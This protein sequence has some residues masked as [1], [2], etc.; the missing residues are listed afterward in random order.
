MKQLKVFLLFTFVCLFIG[1]SDGQEKPFYLSFQVHQDSLLVFVENPFVCPAFIQY[2]DLETQKN[3]VVRLNA[4]EQRKIFS[5]ASSEMDSLSIYNAYKFIGMSY[6]D[7]YLTSY[8][9]LY[10]YGLP[11]LKGK[12]YKVMQGQNT[13]FTHKGA[14]SKYA[15]DF[16]MAVGQT[17]CAM[18]DGVVVRTVSEHDKTG[19]SKKYKDFANYI[20]LYHKDGLFTQYVHLKK[21]GVLVKVGDSVKKGQ[22]IGYSGNTGMST[23]PHLHFAVFKPT[24]TGLVSIPYILD[25]I[26]TH[27]YKKGKYAVNN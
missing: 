7:P 26:T 14:F 27:R 15:I 8:D 24:K 3:N 19:T 21:D 2:E 10:N 16:D 18:K 22:A 13:N 12:Q 11:F 6:G 25:S 5:F 4:K 17:I 20:V 1:C 9:T 23:A